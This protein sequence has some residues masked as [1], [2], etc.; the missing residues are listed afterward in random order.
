[1]GEKGTIYWDFENPYV[2][3]R[4]GTGLEKRQALP[5]EWQVNDMYVEEVRHFVNCIE[6]GEPCEAPLEQGIA[7]LRVALQARELASGA[8]AGSSA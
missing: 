6:R 4:S 8:A 1:M 3:V 7:A 5:A 2:E